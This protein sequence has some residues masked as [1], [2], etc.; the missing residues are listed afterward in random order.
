MTSGYDAP[1]AVSAWAAA[2]QSTGATP[3]TLNHGKWSAAHHGSGNNTPT[4]PQTLTFSSLNGIP[5]LYPSVSAQ[6]GPL[7]SGGLSPCAF[8]NTATPRNGTTT[9]TAYPFTPSH[10]GGAPT[11]SSRP[12]RSYSGRP[13]H[14]AGAATKST[15][16]SQSSSTSSLNALQGPMGKLSITAPLG[17]STSYN[18]YTNG[19]FTPSGISTPTGHSQ[20]NT[21]NPHSRNA[22]TPTG[23]TFNAQTPY[24]Y[25]GLTPTGSATTPTFWKTTPS[26]LQQ[27]AAMNNLNAMQSVNYN[28]YPQHAVAAPLH[29]AAAMK[30]LHLHSLPPP[31]TLGHPP[32][33]HS[34]APTHLL[35]NGLVSHAAAS[36]APPSATNPASRLNSN[37]RPYQPA[38][39]PPAS[40]TAATGVIGADPHHHAVSAALQSPPSYAD[41]V[42]K[43]A[44]NGR[45]PA[46]S[47]VIGRD[48]AEQPQGVGAG[49]GAA[50]GGNESNIIGT[51][52]SA[53]RG[54]GAGL[55]APNKMSAES[56][57]AIQKL[58][59]LTWPCSPRTA[60]F[61]V[62]KSFG[63]D[64]VHKSIKYNLWCSTE[65][66]NRKLDEAFNESK[67]INMAQNAERRR[68]AEEEGS[69]TKE[70]ATEIDAR[71]TSQGCPVYLFFSVNR[72]GC[73]CGMAQMISNYYSDRHFGSWV[74]DGKWQGSFIVKWIYVKDIPNK[75][76]KDIQLP[77]NDG[78]PVTFSRDTQEIP[79]EQGIEMLTRFIN[80]EP[81]TNILQDFKYYDDRERDIK[82]KRTEQIFLQSLAPAP[83]HKH[84]AMAKPVVGMSTGGGAPSAG[85]ALNGIAQPHHHHHHGAPPPPNA[86]AKGQGMAQSMGYGRGRGAFPMRARRGHYGRG[87]RGHR[88]RGYAA[89]REGRRSYFGGKPADHG[90]Y[91]RGRGR[92]RPR[93]RGRYR[94][95]RGRNGHSAVSVSSQNG[96]GASYGNLQIL[97]R[98]GAGRGAQ[99][100]GG[101]AEEEQAATGRSGQSP[102][103]LRWVRK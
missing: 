77:N 19:A 56:T 75:D 72:S 78:R 91:E 45:D 51:D 44:A 41:A 80:Y 32:S 52:P 14:G 95:D 42:S 39:P 5:P 81:K 21:P 97:K 15:S 70:E 96:G 16:I 46:D 29:P 57:E 55:K 60:K 20:A 87:G 101:D 26:H 10:I 11:A 71:D 23:F 76:L 3:T 18:P 99:S 43:E 13:L 17:P 54:G 73:F 30:G 25:A 12:A 27:T 69:S 92:D 8:T 82:M 34:A 22:T 62:I 83:H 58:N 89:Y 98:G 28:L 9:A 6:S 74:Q 68:L 49:S 90:G 66:G 2:A 4:A 24:T 47:Q 102:N 33:A 31:H 61:Y 1:T 53:D 48:P 37:A 88:G 7:Q 50:V 100:G 67:R 36:R 86:S 63:E 85:P 93:P 65:R 64:D 103:H 59:P 38:A 35:S 84:A 79:F 40:G 94:A